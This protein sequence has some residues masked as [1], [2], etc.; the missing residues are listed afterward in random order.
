MCYPLSEWEGRSSDV[1]D[2]IV[3]ARHRR[4]LIKPRHSM[5]ATTSAMSPGRRTPS[6]RF[7]V[8]PDPYAETQYLRELT[9]EVVVLHNDAFDIGTWDAENWNRKA[10]EQAFAQQFGD[11]AS[12][13]ED[14]NEDEDE[15]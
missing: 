9:Y 11:E 13:E 6:P 5:A 7:A 14:G 4:P 3:V 1:T 2:L 10:C 15:E 8:G 12:E